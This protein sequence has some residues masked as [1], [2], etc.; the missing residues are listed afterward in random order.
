RCSGIY[1][2][3]VAPA[4]GRRAHLLALAQRGIAVF[5]YDKRGFGRT[6]LDREHRSPGASYGK[7]NHELELSDVEHWLEYLAQRHPGVPLFLTGYSATRRH[8]GFSSRLDIMLT[9]PSYQSGSLVFSFAT[10]RRAPPKVETVAKLSGVICCSPHIYLTYPN[11][12]A[13][14]IKFLAKPLCAL[15]PN[16]KLA[17]P[18][19]EGLKLKR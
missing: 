12:K 11:P 6:A 14:W 17:A 19:P 7:T 4:A 9:T 8:I 18:M 16:M 5:A 13:N 10:R 1:I 15:V 2:Y 3:V